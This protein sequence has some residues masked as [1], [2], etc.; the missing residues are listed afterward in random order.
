[1]NHGFVDGNKRIGFASLL[2]FLGLNGFDLRASPDEVIHFMYRHLEDG[3]FR[4][5]VLDDWLRAH[6]ARLAER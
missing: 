3:S 4:K 5:D 2:V 1:M 6:T